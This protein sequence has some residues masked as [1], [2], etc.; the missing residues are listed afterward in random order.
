MHYYREQAPLSFT[1]KARVINGGC[2]DYG[3]KQCTGS[4][5]GPPFLSVMAFISSIGKGKMIVEVCS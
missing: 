2:N 1:K 5:A 3:L 4:H